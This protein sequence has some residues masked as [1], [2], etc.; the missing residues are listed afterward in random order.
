MTFFPPV[1]VLEG[2]YSPSECADSDHDDESC[3]AEILDE[4]ATSRGEVKIRTKSLSD[5]KFLRARF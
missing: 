5:E 1:Q 2:E 3:D 4:L